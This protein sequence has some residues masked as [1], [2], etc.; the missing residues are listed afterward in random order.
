MNDANKK[1]EHTYKSF[2]QL[3]AEIFPKLVEEEK[4][5]ENMDNVKYL[6]TSLANKTFNEVLRNI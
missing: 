6:A 1:Y 2:E 5:K 4:N 3:K